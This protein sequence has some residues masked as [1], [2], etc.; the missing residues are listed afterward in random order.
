MLLYDDCSIELM[1]IVCGLRGN[2]RVDVFVVIDI[3]YLLVIL[4]N[5][6]AFGYLA[7]K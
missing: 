6:Y 4:C 5:H 3:V 1:L 7:G 2:L